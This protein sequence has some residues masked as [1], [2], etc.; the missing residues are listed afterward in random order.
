MAWQ[1]RVIG[2][3]P[4]LVKSHPVGVRDEVRS[5]EHAWRS[6]ALC[7]GPTFAEADFTDGLSAH[8]PLHTVYSLGEVRSN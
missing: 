8:D 3:A 5:G 4:H 6:D 7:C 2:H 1:R